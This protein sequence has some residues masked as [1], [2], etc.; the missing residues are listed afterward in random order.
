MNFSCNFIT[1]LWGCNSSICSTDRCH[2]KQ[3]DRDVVTDHSSTAKWPKY[4]HT[5]AAT[6][7][8]FASLGSASWAHELS[9]D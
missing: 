8:R 9:D 6:M 4:Y 1:S 2:K 7:G 3:L 5:I